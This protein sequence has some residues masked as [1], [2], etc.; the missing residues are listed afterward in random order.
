MLVIFGG[1]KRQATCPSLNLPPVGFHHHYT[2]Q[3]KLAN[4]LT[5]SAWLLDNWILLILELIEMQPL[6]L[7]TLKDQKSLNRSHY[8]QI[9]PWATPVLKYAQL[10]KR[11][12]SNTLNTSVPKLQYASCNRW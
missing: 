3:L 7:A 10:C 11:S 9:L 6:A 5:I 8:M 1:N 2:A 12:Q 4:T